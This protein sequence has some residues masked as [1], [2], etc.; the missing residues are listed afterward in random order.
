MLGDAIRAAREE[1]RL[2]QKD[3]AQTAGVSRRHLSQMERGEANVSVAVLSKVARALNLKEVALDG[4]SLQLAGDEATAEIRAHIDNALE[5]LSAAKAI[6]TGLKPPRQAGRVAK[7]PS[8]S[9]PSG[10][11]TKPGGEEKSYDPVGDGHGRGGPT[12]R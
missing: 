3:L 11:P 10:A 12:K 1:R 2:S 6:L 5:E 9:L 7:R 8:Q 4:L